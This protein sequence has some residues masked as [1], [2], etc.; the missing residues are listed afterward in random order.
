MCRGF[1]V[2]VLVFFTIEQ[3][4][5][6]RS[7][8]LSD[9]LKGVQVVSDKVDILIQEFSLYYFDTYSYSVFHVV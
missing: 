8:T 5:D 4:L 6:Q 3:I 9:L 1:V 7:G 2:V